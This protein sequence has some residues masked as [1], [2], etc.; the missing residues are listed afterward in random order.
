MK[1]SEYG[2]TP[3]KIKKT[4]EVFKAQK[5]LIDSG[6]IIQYASGVFGLNVVPK[7]ALDNLTN[8]IKSTF[9]KY[10]LIEVNLP[11]LHP[12][13]IW[14][15]S[16]RY[17]G[18]IESETMLITKTNQGEFCLAP[19]AEEAVVELAKANIFSHKQ[20]PVTYFQIG[21]KFR[22]EIRN[23]GFMFRG[24]VFT[25]FD[26]YSFAKDEE[27]SKDCYQNIKKAYDEI[28]KKL[29]LPV[30][31]IAADPGQIGGSM[32]EEYMLISPLGEDTILYD[33]EDKLGLNTEIL[34]YENY[35]EILKDKYGISDISKFEKVK[36]IELG[37]VF[38]LGRKYSESMDFTYT[39]ENEE[40]KYYEMG[41]YGIG[42]TRLLA[43]IYEYF[44]KKD[45]NGNLL[46][47]YLPKSIAPYMVQIVSS[48]NRKDEAEKLYANLNENNIYSILDDRYSKISLGAKIN[49]V[50]TFGTPYLA[51][52]GDKNPDIIE[53]ED[54][55]TNEKFEFNFDDFLIF[56]ENLKN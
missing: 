54:R 12:K 45:E 28:F 14:E 27:S 44:A 53:V 33:S 56:F 40:K 6:Q 49:E 25:M 39:D 38:N 43:T 2:L 47:L 32:S 5:H 8:L 4:D 50:K 16:G 52:L 34:E 37:H 3:V 46:S 26:A 36:S 18:Y 48:E 20:L 10:G 19:T 55:D 31:P 35:E 42:V 21:E 15:N 51:I 17:E 22:N 9:D 11:L 23:R 30:M 13:A 1:I 7:K 41:C 29:N 24:K